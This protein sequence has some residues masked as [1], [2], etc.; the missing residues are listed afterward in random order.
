MILCSTGQDLYI[1][2]NNKSYPVIGLKLMPNSS[3]KLIYNKVSNKKTL[4]NYDTFL[5][6]VS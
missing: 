4:R 6:F 3:Y 1:Y 5:L 2:I